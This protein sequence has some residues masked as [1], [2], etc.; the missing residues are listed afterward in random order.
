MLIDFFD[1]TISVFCYFTLLIILMSVSPHQLCWQ[2]FPHCGQI[3]TKKLTR[4]WLI[5]YNIQYICKG[6]KNKSSQH[7]N[8]SVETSP[9]YSG[10]CTHLTLNSW[11]GS[12]GEGGST[13]SLTK[14]KSDITV[15]LETSQTDE[16]L[17]SAVFYRN[18]IGCD[19]LKGW[20][21]ERR[22]L[23]WRGLSHGGVQTQSQNQNQKW[24]LTISGLKHQQQIFHHPFLKSTFQYYC[25]S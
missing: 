3:S 5:L 4:E 8:L 23:Q 20:E 13:E 6:Q 21:P 15:S 12:L 11:Y 25:P 19:S 1:K 7:D 16:G 2:S 9:S 24:H 10:W 18:M 22:P 17:T 14:K